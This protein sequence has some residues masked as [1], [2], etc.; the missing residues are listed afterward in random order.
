MINV[1]LF[2][3]ILVVMGTEKKPERIFI[4]KML[5]VLITR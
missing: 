1:T 4:V 2:V 3:K 5:T